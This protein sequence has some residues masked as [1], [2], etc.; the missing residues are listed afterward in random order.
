MKVFFFLLILPLA[1]FA[2]G[3]T[4]N[5]F[6]KGEIN[7]YQLQAKR[8]NIIRDN[9][10]IPHIYGKS[11]A[12]AVFGLLYAQCED[13]F[14][15]VEMNYIE[16]L[17][18]MAEIKGE[19]SL[20][21]D[22]QIRLLIDTTDAISDYNK[23]EPWMKKLLNAY[24]D[25]INFYLYTHPDT[26][27]ALLNRFKPWYPLLWTDGSIGAINTA[28][29]T[30]AELRNFYSGDKVTYIAEP[31]D[32][33]NQTGSNGFAFSPK[34]TAS[35]NAILYINPHVTFYFR[36][37][38]QVSSE[39]GL[40]AYGAVTWGQMFVY[41]GF[42][43]YC[44]WMHT[45]CNV[46]VSDVYAEKI[47]TKNNQLFYEFDKQLKPVTQ[48]KISI[49][50]K[51][52][53]GLKTKIF[54]TYFTHHGP[55]MAKRNDQWISLKSYNRSMTSL[56]QSWKRTKA[57]G[58][59]E[60][61]KI[62]DLR[63]NTS[64]STVFAD[65]KGN[66]AYWHGNFVPIRD[67]KYN[68]A[69][70][71][72]GSTSATEWKGLHNVDETVHVYNPV[73]GWLQNCNSTPFSAAGIESP[74]KANFPPYMAP[75]GENF[76]G[77]NAVKVL[78]NEKKY[79]IDKVILAGYD[80]NLAAFEVLIPSLISVFEKN[81][82]PNDS[83][84]AALNEPI[85]ELKNWNFHSSENSVATTLA[86][87]WAAK[88]NPVLQRLYTDEGETDQVEN[89]KRFAANAT[90]EQ[91]LPPLLTVVN[92]LKKK[93][94]KW[95]IQWG[96]INRYQRVSNDI[97]QKYEDNQPS[98]PVGFASALWGMLPSY[99]SRYYPNTQKRYGVSGNSFI[100]AVEFGPK[101]K[102]KS[103]LAGG[104]SGNINSK[105]FNDQLEMYTKGKFKDVLFYKDDVLKNA[106]R[107]YHPGE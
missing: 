5:K 21:D 74:K 93:F 44:G 85:A 96:E 75:D 8:V 95:Q 7:R 52:S 39:E 106:E 76:R 101:I 71:M 66:I 42:N 27:P 22:L 15:R 55:I 36:P 33:E 9:W 67:R 17:G 58:F 86:I 49:N 89:T 83:L 18:R 47:I 35:G 16:K 88:L 53:E 94:G 97:Q 28:D 56:I 26:K 11:D 57:K 60:Y 105:H 41:Q 46:D 91:V 103:L 77:V 40:N 14:K 24:A 1:I 84:Y 25:G 54:T 78:N 12:D 64:N 92:D 48:K 99:N 59:E 3:I 62:M 30:T 102:A 61:K 65:N 90:V 69:N 104:E 2:Q 50:Y 100:C 4:P 87:E 13:D 79:T 82:K 72:D 29:I 63:A 10:G 32:P 80:T 37:E 43:D 45:S 23:A 107:T 34:I 98:V 81:I 6:S 20:Y 38:V 68:W 70:V 31:K 51:D 19:S 73:N